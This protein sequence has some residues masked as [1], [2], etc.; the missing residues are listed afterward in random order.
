MSDMKIYLPISSTGSIDWDFMET[1]IT[2]EAR[3]AIRGVIEWKDK[4]IAKTKELVAE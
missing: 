4:V 3:L 1:L 2:A